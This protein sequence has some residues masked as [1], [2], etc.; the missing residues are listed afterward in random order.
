MAQYTVFLEVYTDIDALIKIKSR[1]NA[2]V[3]LVNIDMISSGF[4][5]AW[6]PQVGYNN[7]TAPAAADWWMEFEIN[8]VKKGTVQPVN[9]E[10][11]DASAIDIDGNADL[12]HEY[13]SFY[14]LNSYLL[15]S[16]SILALSN[17][18]NGTLQTIG[19]RFDGPTANFT[20]IDTGS[21]S[22]MVT[23]NY[24]NT[25]T[26]TVRAG[27]VSTGASGASERMYSF[28]FK[29][30]NYNVPQQIIL[31]VKLKSFNAVLSSSQV[32]LNWV[33][34]L[35]VNFSHYVVERSYDGKE[36]DDVTM[37]FSKEQQTADIS[38][39]YSE[40]LRPNVSGIIYYR[41]KNG[42]CRWRI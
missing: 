25:N 12:I 33:S 4:D 39:S 7:G 29:D 30:F 31:P 34:A 26:F 23:S 15:E 17:I 38:Y 1:S 40:V 28:Y 42:R 18:I 32:I 41:L 20:N 13:V 19:K 36:F 22:V 5:K 16:N 9:V 10:E 3:Y 14:G 2:L 8:F 21:T 24:K 6:Q 11:F 37:V 27:G 35:E